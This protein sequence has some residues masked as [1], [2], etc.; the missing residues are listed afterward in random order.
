MT[1]TEFVNIFLQAFPKGSQ[2]AIDFSTAILKLA[3]NGELQRIHD[4]WLDTESCTKRNVASAATELGLNTFW[5]LFLITGCASIFCCLVYWTRM[6]IRHRKVS[7]ERGV[8]SGEVVILNP[9]NPCSLRGSFDLFVWLTGCVS[10]GN[11]QRKMSRLE[12]SKS[13]LKSLVT[14]IEEKE[15][16]SSRRSRRR[17]KS[18]EIWS[19]EAVSA[20]SS[21]PTA[22]AASSRRLSRSPESIRDLA[23]PEL[24]M[25]SWR[26][27]QSKPTTAPSSTVSQTAA[28]SLPAQDQSLVT[29]RTSAR[30]GREEDPPSNQRESAGHAAAFE[31]QN[32]KFRDLGLPSA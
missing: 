12:A 27:D 31:I 9:L 14:F 32:F 6:V 5:G 30:E 8:G 28:T 25:P 21:M 1:C 13:F 17:K 26:L 10:P 4:L 29:E 3:E 11:V 20:S 7:R 23:P 19:P 24:A 2:L 22:A 15:E 18:K 16:P